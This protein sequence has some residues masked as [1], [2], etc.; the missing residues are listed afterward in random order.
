MNPPFLHPTR[1]K[2]PKQFS[3]QSN[4]LVSS[5]SPTPSIPLV[6][7]IQMQLVVNVARRAIPATIVP[8]LIGFLRNLM[9]TL[10][11]LPSKRRIGHITGV[12]SATAIGCTPTR[13]MTSGR[14]RS[15]L[16]ARRTRTRT[17]ISS[18]KLLQW[19]RQQ[20]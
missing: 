16:R 20:T 13:N 7:L 3:L 8:Y 17:K 18:N 11:M 9:V 12:K 15:S 4:Q 2:S 1:L 14:R 5:G 10:A 6:P 19:N